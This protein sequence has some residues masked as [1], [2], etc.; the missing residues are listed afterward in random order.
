MKKPGIAILISFIALSAASQQ[1][2][3]GVFGGVSA[4]NGDLTEQIFPKKVTNGVIGITGNYEISDQIVA[5]AGFSYTIIGGAD[6][7]SKQ[8][9]LVV[10]N[11]S[12]ETR[13]FEF[14]ALGEYYLFNLYERRYSPYGYAGLAVFHFDPYA[15]YGNNQ[16]AFL[17][18]LSTEGQGIAGYNV[19][20]YKKIQFAIPFGGGFKFVIND[21]LRIALEGGLRKLFTDYLDDISGNYVDRNDLLAARGQLAVDLAYRG[22]EVTGG[23]PAYPSKGA[24]RGSPKAKDWYYFAG[25]H[26]TYRLG[27]GGLGL[28]SGRGGGK[29]RT[30]CPKNPN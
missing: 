23:N 14:S 18:P 24:Q 12:F 5:R 11:L 30:G 19:R 29:N 28:F 6:R 2:H 16:K 1:L 3:I 8:A 13:L 21:N 15:R 25:L 26:L 4:Y 20:P 10:R 9:D 22:D 17:R 27:G 7:Y